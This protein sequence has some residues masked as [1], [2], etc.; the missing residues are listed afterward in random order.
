[1]GFAYE[2]IDDKETSCNLLVASLVS[3]SDDDGQGGI[4]FDLYF[5][6]KTLNRVTND[7]GSRIGISENYLLSWVYS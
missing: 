2:G 7:D 1:M 3:E 5:A 6:A 4:G